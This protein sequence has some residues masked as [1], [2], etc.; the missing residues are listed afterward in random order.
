MSIFIDGADLFDSVS[1]AVSCG[2]L[3]SD[4]SL[5]R[6]PQEYRAYAI[7]NQSKGE[8]YYLAIKNDSQFIPELEAILSSLK[9]NI[10]LLRQWQD[11]ELSGEDINDLENEILNHPD[12]ILF[13]VGEAISPFAPLVENAMLYSL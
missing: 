10:L 8:L 3:A 5:A 2:E 7:T 12:V 11:G 4:S 9:N 6:N 1:Q 13:A